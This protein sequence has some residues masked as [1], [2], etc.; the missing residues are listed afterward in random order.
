MQN[1]VRNQPFIDLFSLLD[2]VNSLF[3]AQKKNTDIISTSVSLGGLGERI[4]TSGLLNPIQA[5]Y[6]AALHPD[7]SRGEL[8]SEH[9][10]L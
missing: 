3:G 1:T 4:R 9:S 5:R 8:P 10:I 6:Q 2:E 7:T